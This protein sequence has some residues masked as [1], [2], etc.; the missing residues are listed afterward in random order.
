M[1]DNLAHPAVVSMLDEILAGRDSDEL[2]FITAVAHHLSGDTHRAAELYRSIQSADANKNL[3]NLDSVPPRMPTI[4]TITA[5]F[6]TLYPRDVW[7]ILRFGFGAKPDDIFGAGAHDAA[8]T[9]YLGLM[10]LTAVSLFVLGVRRAQPDSPVVSIAAFALAIAFIAVALAVHH[11]ASL[12]VKLP[13]SGKYSAGWIM[14][15][16]KAFPFPPDPTAQAAL[17]RAMAR[18]QPMRF[19]WISVATAVLTAVASGA[20]LAREQLRRTRNLAVPLLDDAAE[21][22]A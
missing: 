12:T 2:R 22:K 21:V 8:Q 20:S 13:V 10:L 14:E 17:P 19:F 15:Y 9:F 18:S 5:A 16:N 3:D 1:F 11:S 6:N 7:R 4:E